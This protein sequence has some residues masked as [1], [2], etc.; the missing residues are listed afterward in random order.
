VPIGKTMLNNNKILQ[1]INKS[2][3]DWV[4]AGFIVIPANI[5]NKVNAY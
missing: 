3:I 5:S 1:D 2:A 4:N